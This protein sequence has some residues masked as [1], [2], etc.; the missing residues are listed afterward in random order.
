MACAVEAVWPT[1]GVRMT[2]SSRRISPA[3]WILLVV[4]AGLMLLPWWRNHSYL[5]DLYDYGLV[6]AATGQIERGDRPYVN[7]TTPIQAGFLGL[8]W[9]IEKMGGGNYAALTKGGAGLALLSGLL[10]P[11]MLVRRW[12]WWAALVVGAAVT[13]GGAVQH[14]ILW[15]NALGVFCLALV[16]WAAAIAPILRRSDWP[17]HLLVAMGLFFGGVN[18]LNFHLVALAAALAWTLRAGLLGRA[19]WRSVGGTLLIWVIAGVLL[20]VLAELLWT[21]ASLKLWAVNVVGTATESRLG[22]LERIWS[23]D[24]LFTTIHDYYGPLLLPQAGLIGLLLSLV[25]LAGSWSQNRLDRGLLVLAVVLVAMAAAGLLVTNHEIA[26]MGVAA[27]IVLLAGIWLGFGGEIRRV[28]VAMAFIAPVAVLAGAGWWS[29]WL[30]QRSQFG[31]SS[32]LR[33]EYQAAEAAHPAYANLRGLRLPPEMFQSMD[34][35]AEVL[36]EQNEAGPVPVFYGPGLEFLEHSF[37]R[38][39]LEREPLWAHWGTS[40]DAEAIERLR[41]AAESHASHRTLVAN[42][43]FD[44][45]PPEIQAVMQRDFVRDLVGPIFVRW[46]HRDDTPADLSDSFDTLTHLGGNVD[47][48]LLH[49]DR[50]PFRVWRTEEGTSILGTR[51]RA[52]QVL[53]STPVYRLNGNAVVA[54]IPGMGEERVVAD[55]KIIV[56]GA[57]P[58]EVRWSK[59]VELPAGQQSIA[60]P[61]SVDGGGK[62]LLLWVT[63]PAEQPVGGAVTG[64]RDLQINHAAEGVRAP[65]LRQDSP[66]DVTVNAG[67][68]ESLLGSVS[69]RPE[70]M[71]VRNGG[72]VAKGLELSPGGEVWL[73]TDGM[74]GEFRAQVTTPDTAGKTPM[75]RVV[76][77]KGGRLQLVQQEW[78]QRG[79]SVDIRVWTAEPGGWVGILVDFGVDYSPVWVRAT[80]VTLQP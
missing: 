49:F 69:W 29:A 28:W 15:H 73:H 50:H 53:L 19:G 13:A 59:R 72:P 52:G 54:R 70:Q 61:F 80:E 48:R 33:A 18:K 67:V 22:L 21:G 56:H 76:W 51:Q 79:R 8:S 62:V 1:F 42:L 41:D 17:W 71:V 9:L 74:T 32:A 20:P 24:F 31:Y 37:P 63:R 38:Q 40:Y 57:S 47:G 35:I 4:V 55:F 10:L 14:T 43:A 12:P 5:R 68:V 34:R 25:T 7:F 66:P 23:R 46:R 3:F 6:I 77:Y 44:H 2:A 78:A 16:V 27:W 30:G 36:A 64:Y 58:E 11:L 75:V 60:V 39:R 65:R 45:W 26:S